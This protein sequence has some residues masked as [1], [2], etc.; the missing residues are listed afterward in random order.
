MKYNL[1]WFLILTVTVAAASA[2]SP[3]QAESLAE[4]AFY[5]R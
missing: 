3:A 4:I 2:V 1:F 5:V